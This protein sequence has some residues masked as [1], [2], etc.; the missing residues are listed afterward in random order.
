MLRGEALLKAATAAA[1]GDK[2]A[3]LRAA[4]KALQAADDD[5]LPPAPAVKVRAGV[6]VHVGGVSMPGRSTGWK[7][8]HRLRLLKGGTPCAAVLPPAASMTAR[9]LVH[10]TCAG[11]HYG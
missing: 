7:T 3:V 9:R 2:P 5:A 10:G 4:A 8:G 6:C 11:G 1:A